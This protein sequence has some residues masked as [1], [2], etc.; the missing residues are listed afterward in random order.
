MNSC[1]PISRD[2]ARRLCHFGT[3][4]QR[5]TRM[6]PEEEL[7]PEH[8]RLQLVTSSNEMMCHVHPPRFAPYVRVGCKA[9]RLARERCVRS[10]LGQGSCM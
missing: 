4:A 6:V 1:V 10:R 2:G 5:G 9:S 3:T 7:V 8:R